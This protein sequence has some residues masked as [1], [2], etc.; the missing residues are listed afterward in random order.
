MRWHPDGKHVLFVK[1]TG[2]NVHAVFEY[3]LETKES[4]QVFKNAAEAIIFDWALDNTHLVCVL[5]SKSPPR[6]TDG[7]WIGKPAADK[8]WQVP[9]S[10]ALAQGEL[11]AVLEQLR[12]TMPIWSPKAD[13]FVFVSSQVKDAKK[14]EFAHSL[15]LGI[16]ATRAV[17]KLTNGTQ[18]PRDI[19]WSPDGDRVGHVAGNDEGPLTFIR[20]ADKSSTTLVSNARTFI[21]WDDKNTSLA[22]V[23]ADPIPHGDSTEWVFLLMPN[24]RYRDALWLA[25][26]EGSSPGKKVFSGMQITFPQWSPKDA[27]VSLWATFNPSYRS[28][29]SALLEFL[30]IVARID[31]QH[32]K[33][34]AINLDL[35]RLRPGDP[36]LLFDAKTGKLDWMA[37]DAAEQIQ[38]GHYYQMKREYE[39]AWKWYE[40]ANKSGK[41]EVVRQ[42]LFFQYFCLTKLH[43]AAEGTK[44][45]AQFDGE[46]WPKLPKATKD[47]NA[48]GPSA[49][50][51]VLTLAD[52][53]SAH[54]TM[55][56]DL[57]VAELFLSLDAAEDGERY[58]RDALKNASTD[59][60]RLNKA[61]VL[62]QFLLLTKKHQEYLAL[63][64]ATL[65]PLLVSLDAFPTGQGEKTDS[66]FSQLS[67][68]VGRQMAV[69]PLCDPDFVKSFTSKQTQDLLVRLQEL[70][71]SASN[72]SGSTPCFSQRTCDSDRRRRLKR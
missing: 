70:R 45:L 6:D 61:V 50:E 49:A 24:P 40:K 36:A 32:G 30:A 16:P 35:L 17:V 52:P 68:F 59:A 56:Q 64:K 14:K 37:I 29:S 63:C 71:T 55:L 48:K 60:V 39:T 65:L 33:S 69:L 1:Q 13:R 47:T 43:R 21:G 10:R 58:F 11:P 67:Y 9:E 3:D 15:N 26:A 34:S 18:R 7:I 72:A 46:F 12:A 53:K 20:V 57:Y 22:Y 62:S 54:G 25:P 5:G 41:P 66:P 44:K 23:T 31:A 8:W 38:V 51:F 2:Q 19:H 4:R 28:W 27:K 42:S